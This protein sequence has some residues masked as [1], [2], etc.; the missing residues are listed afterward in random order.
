MEKFPPNF[1]TELCKITE[2]NVT[3]LFLVE[4]LL[5]KTGNQRFL[6]WPGLLNNQKRIDKLNIV[7]NSRC[8]NFN[9]NYLFRY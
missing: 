6:K 7:G 4:N 8:I 5:R 1:S 9:F 2:V 3:N